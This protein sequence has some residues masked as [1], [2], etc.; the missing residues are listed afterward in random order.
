MLF[1]SC[2][3]Q[4]FW[5]RYLGEKCNSI[6]GGTYSKFPSYS[7]L[8]YV[9]KLYITVH[10]YAVY[11]CRSYDQY[12]NLYHFISKSSHFFTLQKYTIALILSYSISLFSYSFLTDISFENKSFVFM[13]HSLI[14]IRDLLCLKKCTIFQCSLIYEQHI[15]NIS[16]KFSIS[17]KFI[18]T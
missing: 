8:S 18:F 2:M 7:F 4:H 5:A 9:S 11:G 3:P 14:V 13:Q 12:K 10:D 16:L 1:K 15:N 17:L 6:L